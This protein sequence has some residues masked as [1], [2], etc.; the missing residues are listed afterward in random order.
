M[1]TGL[2]MKISWDDY[3]KIPDKQRNGIYEVENLVTFYCVNGKLHREDG[4]AAEGINGYKG[5]FI[6]GKRHRLD[7]TA[8][9]WDE[10]K[11]YWIEGKYYTKEE[12]ESAAYLYKNGLQD[13]M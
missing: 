7:G 10:I 12:F 5:W 9:E 13:Y 6:N 11:Q 4:P 1:I 2:F 3:K 8:I